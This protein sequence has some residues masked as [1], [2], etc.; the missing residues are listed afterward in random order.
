YQNTF[1][2]IPARLPFRPPRLTP[3][4]VIP[5]TQTAVVAG[6]GAPGEEIFTDRYGRVKVDFHWDSGTGVGKHSCWGRVAQVWAGKSWGASFWPRVGQEVVV[7]FLEG[8]PDQP[9]IVGSVYNEAQ[10]PP[11]LGSG[12][13]PGND[14]DHPN[15]PRL[16][17]IKTCSTP[18]GKGFNE[19]R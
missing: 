19:L 16:S 17:G 15:N 10:R 5:G 1:T 9:L 14:P 12:K 3:R 7:A 6:S 13:A 4:P 2:C 11:Y 8:D 18:G